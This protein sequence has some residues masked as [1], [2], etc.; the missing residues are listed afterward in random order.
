MPLSG[1]S[2]LSDRIIESKMD[3]KWICGARF[4][5]NLNSN[6]LEK[7]FGLNGFKWHRKFVGTNKKNYVF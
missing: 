4:E 1:M 2:K 6:L 5:K 3:V 7:A